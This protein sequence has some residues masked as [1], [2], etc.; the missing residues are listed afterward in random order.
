MARIADAGI[1]IYSRFCDPDHKRIDLARWRMQ[2]AEFQAMMKAT[3]P[4]PRWLAIDTMI[5]VVGTLI[6]IVAALWLL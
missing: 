4:I 1:A 5:L 3:K 6:M 2:V